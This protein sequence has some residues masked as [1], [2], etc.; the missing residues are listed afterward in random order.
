MAAVTRLEHRRT[1]RRAAGGD[2]GDMSVRTAIEAFLDSPR[3]RRSQHTRRAYG[4]VLDGVAE[5]VGADRP[6]V[7]VTEAEIAAAVTGLWGE[8][9]GSTWNRNRAAVGSWLAWCAEVQHWVAPGLAPSLERRRE[10]Q[11]TTRAVSRSQIDRL[12]RRRD[13][14]LR[15]KTL[16]RMLYETAARAGEVLSLNVEDLDL[17]NKQ[18]RVQ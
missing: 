5:A 6:L 13:V 15:E 7:D 4:N 11:D 3:V 12:C 14:P 9:A 18:A 16:W 17:A 2:A 1:A 10:R 8:R